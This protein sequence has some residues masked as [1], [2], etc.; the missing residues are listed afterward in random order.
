M[1]A[2]TSACATRARDDHGARAAGCDGARVGHAGMVTRETHAA[3]ARHRHGARGAGRDGSGVHHTGV[4]FLIHIRMRLTRPPDWH[5]GLRVVPDDRARVWWIHHAAA[6]AGDR[7][8]AAAAGRDRAGADHADV[9]ANRRIG[10]TTPTRHI[11]VAVF[12]GH[13]AIAIHLHAPL[14]GAQRVALQRDRTGAVRRDV[15]RHDQASTRREAHIAQR[16]HGERRRGVARVVVLNR[17]VAQTGGDGGIQVHDRARVGSHVA[18]SE[19]AHVAG[20]TT[21][22]DH[23][24]THQIVG[25]GG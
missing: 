1:V 3:G 9:V 22:V 15:T 13:R 17:E 18:Q 4:A 20:V 2:A 7:D 23:H 11:H 14:A 12:G 19:V 16:R 21:A 5:A 8:I 10:G 6:S 25:L 24:A